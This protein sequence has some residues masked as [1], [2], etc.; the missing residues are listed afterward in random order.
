MPTTDTQTGRYD[1]VRNWDPLGVWYSVIDRHSDSE[2]NIVY[3][4][5]SRKSAHD[6]ADRR[7]QEDA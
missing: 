5:R 6:Y 2:K 3:A 4:T 7:N 1:V